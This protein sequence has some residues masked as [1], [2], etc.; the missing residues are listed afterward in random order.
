M[1]EHFEKRLKDDFEEAIVDGE[2]IPPITE[3]CLSS[4]RKAIS[5]ISDDFKK[6]KDRKGFR[7]G[8]F[9]T[10]SGEINFVIQVIDT[11]KRASIFVLK[12]GEV[13]IILCDTK[14]H[15]RKVDKDNLS[16][17]VRWTVEDIDL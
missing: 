13:E 11:N 4:F 9:L 10:D 15:V 2:N 1:I 17:I 12:T 3:E 16:Q 6:E 5:L 14:N 8:L 7:Y